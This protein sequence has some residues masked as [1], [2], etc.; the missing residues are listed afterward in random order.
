MSEHAGPMRSVAAHEDIPAPEAHSRNVRR[1][2]LT[3]AAPSILVAALVLLPFLDT[4]FTIDDTL[5]LEQATHLLTDPLH[6]TAFETVWSEASVPQRMSQIM[7]SGAVAAWFLVPAALAGGSERIAHLTQLAAFVLAILAT[8]SLALRLGIARRFATIAGLLLAATPAALGMAGTAMP[9]VVAMALGVAGVERAVAWKQDR[10][11]HQAVVA[12]IVLGLAPLARSHLLLVLAV[13]VLLLA[14]DYLVKPSWR[15]ERWTLWVPIAVGPILTIAVTLVTRDPAGT[16]GDLADATRN[17]SHAKYAA[18]NSVAFAIHWV[19][20]LP[21]ALPWL[22][23]RSR[24]IVRRWWVP[25]VAAAACTG[26]ILA[27]PWE[28]T[29]WPFL[30]VPI[31]AIGATV[32]FDVFA[33]AWARRDSTQ[34]TLG[35][36]LLVALP[37]AIYLHMPSKYLLASAP[38]AALLVARSMAA[39]SKNLF[40]ALAAATLAAG[41]ALGVAILRANATFARAGRDAAA[42]MIAPSVAAGHR[43]WFA[44]NWGF[45]WYA[46][47]AGGRVVTLTPPFPAP[48]DLLV[49]AY[50]AEPNVSTLRMLQELYPRVSL[51]RRIVHQDPGGRTMSHPDGAG[52]FSNA[53]G[54]LPWVWSSGNHPLEMVYLWRID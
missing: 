51:I 36:W 17:L 9:D 22:V 15:G 13:A 46:Q 34:L 3:C 45:K 32:L 12:T 44:G 27:S 16:A 47:R 39:A 49:I 35:A 14:G 1:G 5:F 53:W 38:A 33:D 6:P 41:L 29:R 43:V 37:I 48:G 30:A 40:R 52:F 20:A 19:L 23:L 24:P 54:Y 50:R 4:P 42:A 7:P 11:I 21:L 10:R 28:P 8:V 25:A 18:V 2:V 26:G 31:A